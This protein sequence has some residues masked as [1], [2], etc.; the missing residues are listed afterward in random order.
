MPHLSNK[1]KSF[2]FNSAKYSFGATSA[3]ITSLA[4]ITSLNINS[5]AK[6][7]V[8]GS[9]LIVALADNISDTLG[10]HIFQEGESF[11]KKEVWISTGT[12]FLTR[13]LVVAVFVL[14]VIFFPPSIALFLSILY[15]FLVLTFISIVIAKKRQTSALKSVL[16]HLLIATVVIIASKLVGGIIRSLY[17]TS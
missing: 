5:A 3:I 6:L 1:L 10:I 12:N 15:G 14:L 16:E 7:G 8:V 4:L 11:K 2:Y 13:L 17:S 9:L